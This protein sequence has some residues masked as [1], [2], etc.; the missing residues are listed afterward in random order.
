[1]KSRMSRWG[2]AG[3]GRVGE[4]WRAT[5]KR[6]ECVGVLWTMLLVK[7]GTSGLG[8][9]LERSALMPRF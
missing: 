8:L 9:N 3:E 1:M 4:Y 7:T 5:Q 6:H 2:A